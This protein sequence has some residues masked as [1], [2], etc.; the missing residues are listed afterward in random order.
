M[1]SAARGRLK[2]REIEALRLF[3]VRLKARQHV[4]D[5]REY[6][7]KGMGRTDRDSTAE[8]SCLFNMLASLDRSENG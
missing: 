7:A 6:R 5:W 8:V 2:E 3:G 4:P 1:T